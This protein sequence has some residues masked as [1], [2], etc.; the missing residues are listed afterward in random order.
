MPL[1][2]VIARPQGRGNLL[3]K[4][5]MPPRKAQGGMTLVYDELALARV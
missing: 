1:P 2:N 4:C 3:R 5:K